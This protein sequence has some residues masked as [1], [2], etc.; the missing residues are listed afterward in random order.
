MKPVEELWQC[1]EKEGRML[2]LCA[3]VNCEAKN[4]IYLYIHM[5]ILGNYLLIG[6]I[7]F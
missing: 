2:R 7:V 1:Q 6:A 5:S 3:S 4:C